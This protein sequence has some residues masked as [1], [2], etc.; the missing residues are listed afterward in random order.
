MVARLSRLRYYPCMADKGVRLD[1]FLAERGVASRRTCADY[2]RAGRITVNGAVTPIP[3]HRVHPDRDRVTLDGEALATMPERH[4]TI[5][6]NKPRGYVC[7]TNARQGRT[8]YELLRNTP[9]RL[10]PAGRLDKE[11]EG[12]LLMSNDGEL[13]L[14]LT[15]P[16]F[17]HE[18]E[19]EVTVKGD[20]SPPILDRL[21]SRL[22]IDGYRIQPVEV[23]VLAHDRKQDTHV[24]QFRLREG[25]NR[26]IRKMCAA[27]N[28]D[29]V[30]LVRTRIQS[31][32]LNGLDPGHSRP[33][34]E[35]ELRE[36]TGNFKNAQ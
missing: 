11:S 14:R 35:A 34:T 5:A 13:V 25:R 33:L 6:L 26:Q 32:T 8:V 23:Q 17:G 30:R 3:G 1:K 24:L 7:S 15:H 28:L 20:V 18:K 10:V 22:T 12:L 16:R 4:V 2:V 27:A 19:Y 29:V 36:L 21:R 9:E 31:I